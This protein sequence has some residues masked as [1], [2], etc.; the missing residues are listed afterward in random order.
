MAWPPCPGPAGSAL[1]FSM[2]STAGHAYGT[3][4]HRACLKRC[5]WALGGRRCSTSRIERVERVVSMAILASTSAAL[6]AVPTPGVRLTLKS[7]CCRRCL[8][9]H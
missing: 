8:A 3:A 7:R 1:Y 9:I 2:R 6:W 4:Q 5:T